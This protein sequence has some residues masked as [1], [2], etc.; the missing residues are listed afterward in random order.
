[1]V[2]RPPVQEF[3]VDLSRACPDVG[4]SKAAIRRHRPGRQ[5]SKNVGHTAR[6]ESFWFEKTVH[7]CVAPRK[8][9]D[10]RKIAFALLSPVRLVLRSFFAPKRL[11]LN[12]LGG[13]VSVGTTCITALLLESSSTIVRSPSLYF[14][15]CAL[16]C[17]VFL[18]QNVSRSTLSGELFQLEPRA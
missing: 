2:C 7:N 9:L 1:M 3:S 11:P 16:F 5:G 14:L 6:R 10:D 15:R 18:R 12:P 17:A 8:Q 13:T 4:S